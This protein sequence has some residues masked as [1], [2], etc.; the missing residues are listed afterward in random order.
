MEIAIW[1]IMKEPQIH[2]DP[3]LPG[4]ILLNFLWKL[5]QKVGRKLE[6]ECHIMMVEAEL[7]SLV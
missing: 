1:I 4:K 6:A 7:G 3:Q 2:D 5:N